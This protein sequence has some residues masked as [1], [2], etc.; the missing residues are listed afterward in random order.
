MVFSG[1]DTEHIEVYYN[2]GHVA[3][4]RTT[5]HSVFISQLKEYVASC[6]SDEDF[7]SEQ[8]NVRTCF[9]NPLNET[10]KNINTNTLSINKMFRN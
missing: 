8:F 10:V 5:E 9:N 7:F 6:L 1:S 4:M 2:V 3:R